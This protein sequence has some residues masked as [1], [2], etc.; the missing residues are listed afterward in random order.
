MALGVQRVEGVKE[1]FLGAFA[2]GQKL[3]V[4]QNQ[5]V[6]AAHLFLELT[7]S[8]APQRGDQLIHEDFCRHE[9]D[10]ARVLGAPVEL[11]TDRRGQMGLAQ[12]GA[13]IDEQ[14]IVFFAGLAGHRQGGGVGELVAWTDHE[15]SEVIARVESS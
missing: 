10:L 14:R 8:I 12:T 3:D 15:F 1:L 5:S 7:H 4:V 2:A 9:Q 11:M 6:H 13:A